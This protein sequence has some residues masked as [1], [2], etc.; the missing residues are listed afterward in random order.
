MRF[1]NKKA[2]KYP[3]RSKQAATDTTFQRYHRR[4]QQGTTRTNFNQLSLQY[5]AVQEIFRH[6]VNNIYRPDGK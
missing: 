3:L 4:A 1:N 2:H 6:T 5:L